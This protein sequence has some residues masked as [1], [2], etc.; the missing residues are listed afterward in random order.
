[1]S[2]LDQ[3]MR[4][5]RWT[6]DEKR[7]QASDLELLIERL[8]Q[9]ISHLDAAVER[10][11]EASRANLELQRVLPGYRQVMKDRRARLDKSLLDLRGE[12]D[13]LREQITAAFSELKKTEQTVKNREQRQ[14]LAERRKD[15]AVSDE[16]GL[17]LHRRKG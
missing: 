14:R 17:Q 12:L 8:I 9:D 7:R 5:Q 10:E 6:L 2:G 13:K 3:L 16:I 11:I 1:M 4:L 15:Q